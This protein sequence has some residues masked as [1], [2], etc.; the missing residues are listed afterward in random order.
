MLES[1]TLAG[2][3]AGA[4]ALVEKVLIPLTEDAAK[5]FYKD[6]LKDSASKVLYEEMPE[7]FKKAIL[8]A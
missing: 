7:L 6:F 3:G 5:D 2:L 4:K 1:L 8:N